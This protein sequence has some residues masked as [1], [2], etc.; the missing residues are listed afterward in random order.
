MNWF[1]HY[2]DINK[3]IGIINIICASGG[4]RPKP[5]P[6]AHIIIDRRCILK[7]NCNVLHNDQRGERMRMT[8]PYHHL[9]PKRADD[10]AAK[11]MLVV[12]DS[13]NVTNSFP[14]DHPF[15]I[16]LVRFAKNVSERYK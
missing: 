16:R 6:A 10:R 3:R 9:R 14:N 1:A 2:E 11:T 4:V 12:E 13:Q 8:M 15:F 7:A 5:A